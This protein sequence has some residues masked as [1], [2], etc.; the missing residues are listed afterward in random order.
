MDKRTS[1]IAVKLMKYDFKVKDY[2]F[3]EGGLGKGN[4]G[5]GKMG[6]CDKDFSIS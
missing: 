3:L 6:R 4:H 5:R 1:E 2:D